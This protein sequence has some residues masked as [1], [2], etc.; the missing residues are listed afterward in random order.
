[1]NKALLMCD[2]NQLESCLDSPED[3]AAFQ[4]VKNFILAAAPAPTA[5]PFPHVTCNDRATCREA[6]FCMDGWLCANR[7]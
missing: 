6:G 7:A 4:N 1:M 5:A 3:H 2:L